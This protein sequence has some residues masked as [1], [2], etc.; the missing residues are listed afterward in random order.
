MK[1]TFLLTAITIASL[2]LNN[3]FFIAPTVSGNAAP[4]PPT[5]TPITT[6]IAPT[7]IGQG[8]PVPPIPGEMPAQVEQ[9]RARQAMEA[10]LEKYLDYWGPRYQVAPVKVTVEGEWAHGVAEWQSSA[11]TLNGPLHI[12][13]HR[14]P[15]G[16]WQALLPGTDGAYLQWLEAMPERLV[17]AGE[18]SQLRAQVA[19]TEALQ[20]PQAT[21]AVP[22]GIK[23]TGKPANLASGLMRPTDKQA[24]LFASAISSTMFEQFESA[25]IAIFSRGAGPGQIGILEGPSGEIPVGPSSIS[26][27]SDGTVLLLDS[28][29]HRV[30]TLNPNGTIEQTLRIDATAWGV[31]A[32]IDSDNNLYVLDSRNNRLLEY[33]I[34][35]R[36]SATGI[37]FA[38]LQINHL[39]IGPDRSLLIEGWQFPSKS[40]PPIPAAMSIASVTLDGLQTSSLPAYPNMQVTRR[41]MRNVRLIQTGEY[42]GK[43][44]IADK[45]GTV[46]MELSIE[47]Q[48]PLVSATLLDYDDTGNAYIIITALIPTQTNMLLFGAR[49]DKYSPTGELVASTPLPMK[50]FTFPDHP[51]AVARDGTVYQLVPEENRI[52]IVRWATSPA[53][54]PPDQA[55]PTWLPKISSAGSLFKTHKTP[56]PIATEGNITPA[57][58][59]ITCDQIMATAQ[60]Y[61]VHTWTVGPSN[62]YARTCSN[63]CPVGPAAWGIGSTIT[64]VAYKW[65]GW[66]TINDF[67]WK[68]S[69]GYLAGDV[70]GTSCVGNCATGVDCSGYVQQ[71]WQITDQKHNV[72]QLASNT[73]SQHIEWNQLQKG[74]ALARIGSHIVLFSNRDAQGHIAI[75]ESAWGNVY[76]VRYYVDTTGSYLSGYEARRRLNVTCNSSGSCDA[77]NVPSGYT[78][79]AEEGER[80]NFSGTQQVYYGANNCYKVKSFTNG[81]DCNNNNFG[82]PLPGVHKACYVSNPSSGC[83][84][85]SLPSGYVKCAD[86]NGYCSFSGTQQVYYGADSC[87]KVKT[88]TDGVA[89]NNNNFGDPLPG[90]GKAC[91]VPPSCNPNADQIA[92]YANTG[93]GGSC[94]TLGVGDYPNPGYLGSLGNDNAES[95]RVGSNV[96]AILYEHDNYQGRSETFTSDDSNLGDNYIGANSVSSVKVQW[97]AQPPAA[98]TLQSPPNGTVFNEGQGINLSWS[99][100]G[101]EYYGEVWGGPGGTLTFGWQ[102][103]TSKDIGSQWAGYT[104]SWHVKARNSAGTSNWSSTW[105]FTV[106]PAAPSNLSAQ[107][108]SCSQVN[109]YWTDNSGNEEGYKIYRNGSYVG[110]VGMNATSYQDT[111][112]NGNTGYSYYVRAFRGSIESDASNTVNITT[113]PCAPPKPD[114][115]PYAPSGYPYP[116]VPSSV[117]GTHTVNTLYAGQTTY[118][119]WHFINSGNATAS[120]DF[121]VEL[122]VDGTRYVR[123]PYSDYG[124]GWSGGFDDWAETISTP[125]WHTVRLVTDPDNTV[126]ESDETNN[127]WEMQFYWTPSAPYYDDMENGI[128]DWTATGLWHQVDFIGPDGWRRW[129]YGQDST[130]NYDTGMANSGDLTSPPIYIPDTNYYLRFLYYY[131]TETQGPDWDQRWVQIS[132]DGGPFNNILQLYDDP[133][134]WWLHSQAIDLSGY[135]GH[136]IRVRFHFDTIDNAYNAYHGWYIDNFEI[137]ATPPPPCA[138]THEPNNTPTQATAIAYGQALSADIC[139]GGDYDFYQFTGS[140]GDKIVIDIDTTNESWLDSYVFLLDSNGNVLAANDDEMWGEIR[141]SHLGYQLPHDGTYYIK[142]KAWNHP[143][144]GGSEYFYTIHLLNDNTNPSATITWPGNDTWMNPVTQTITVVASDND[145][146][147]RVEFLWHDAD[148]ENSEWV[149]LGADND[150][151]DGWS[152]DFSTSNLPEQRGGAFYIWA[153]DWVGN[154]TGAGVWNLGIDRTP[155]T[156]SISVSPMYRDAPFRDFHVWW[157]ANDNLSGT[158]AYD[159]Q[160]RDGAGGAWTNLVTGTTDTYYRFVGQNGHTYYFRT[161]AYDYAGNIGNYS[162]ETS[163]T[164]QTCPVAADSYEADNTPAYAR[165]IETDGKWQMHN[166]HVEQDQ[167]WVKFVALPGITY[168]L[169]TTN[170]GGHADTVLYLYDRDG[171][172]LLDSNDDDPTNWPASRLIWQAPTAGTYYIKVKHWDPYAYGCTTGYGLSITPDRPIYRSYLPVILR[173]R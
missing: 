86:E 104:Y 102:S 165:L 17:P 64:G 47:T 40:A 76:K 24:P 171:S 113:P 82:D 134:Q 50:T 98:P 35:D 80:C 108:A 39:A 83:D 59:N 121:H 10:A 137:S 71:T 11:K 167:D 26:V 85:T 5:P 131:Q 91:Y 99:A 110:Q 152:W 156:A 100:T 111:G 151:R 21:P 1:K 89:C 7:G 158:A 153:F 49:L 45:N 67:D 78:K 107:A 70:S 143:S 126:A 62:Y 72:D 161:R 145:E 169:A 88:F 56:E 55:P 166:F 44:I 118:F 3:L 65:G 129:W 37:S 148:W 20:R 105:T 79:C 115:R 150:G 87:Y 90:V 172:T 120:G 133:M 12:L 159:V 74:D 106:K 155:P 93:Y 130:N 18:K 38:Q 154:W 119:D 164:V 136:V 109:L 122:W 30:I 135:A 84:A 61:A 73:Y 149:W 9:A 123:Y 127:L 28:V 15:D 125:G 97:R 60:D 141:D 58:S 101:N 146:V 33:K 160:Y 163:Y 53:L 170:T 19:E 173:N 51:L 147:N 54:T 168:T 31:D 92:L 69:Q 6:P 52:R 103:G 81:V 128:N 57:L 4:P 32:I 95:I 13:A 138:D 63:G 68:L 75:Y 94:V 14:L 46:D 139:P 41:G 29:N 77:S 23:G 36:P 114:L 117:Q 48:T 42:S 16:T 2:M 43:I 140:A 116:V 162:D 34:T 22:Q 157:Y 96:Q 25:D 142:M 144:A 132:V 112:L 8:N 66:D 27:A 124:A